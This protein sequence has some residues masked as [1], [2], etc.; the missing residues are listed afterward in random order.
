MKLKPTVQD[1]HKEDENASKQDTIE[2]QKQPDLVS[3]QAL[4]ENKKQ[5][6]AEKLAAEEA[7]RLLLIQNVKKES[8]LE[9]AGRGPSNL[10]PELKA[11]SP[12]IKKP[13]LA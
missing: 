4:S 7:Y 3:K 2:E 10:I 1:T 8:G 13:D 5:T 11:K 6:A 12:E 9:G